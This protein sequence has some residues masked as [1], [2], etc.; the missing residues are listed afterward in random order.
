M[1]SPGNLVTAQVQQ[2]G[3]ATIRLVNIVG[4]VVMQQSANMQPGS[5]TIALKGLG[6]LP[7]GV[8]ELSVEL[9]GNRQLFKLVK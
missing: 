9:N 2:A 1:F 7:A 8:Y 3:K 5:N 4:A 6:E